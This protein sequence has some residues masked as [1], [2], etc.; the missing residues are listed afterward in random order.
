MELI[1]IGVVCTGGYNHMKQIWNL[2]MNPPVGKEVRGGYWPRS[3]G[4][5]ATHCWDPDPEDAKTWAK[6]NGANVVDNYYD[7]VD[8]VDAVIFADYSACGWFPGLTKPYLEAGLPCLINRPFALSMK[9][10]E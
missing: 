7:M 5:V 2:Y 8:K 1:E 9:D 10:A 4:M 6:A 3:T